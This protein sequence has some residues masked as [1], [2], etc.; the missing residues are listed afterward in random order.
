MSSDRSTGL[1]A[2][3]YRAAR[4]GLPIPVLGRSLLSGTGVP[5]PPS[6]PKILKTNELFYHYVLDL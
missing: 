1:K 2:C 5:P 4:S 6:V 3:S